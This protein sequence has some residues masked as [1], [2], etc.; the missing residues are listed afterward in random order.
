MLLRRLSFTQLAAAIGTAWLSCASAWAADVNVVGLFPGRALVEIDRGSPSMMRAGEERAGVRLISA[1]SHAAVFDIDGRRETLQLGQSLSP[2]MQAAHPHVVLRADD[3]GHFVTDGQINGGSARFV[4]DT[5]ATT[6][7]M[8]IAD[9]RRLGLDFRRAARGTAST[10]NGSIAV[11][12]VQLDSVKVGDIVLR[13]VDADILDG[14]S[15]PFVLLGMSFLSRTEMRR[16]AS[17]LTLTRM[18]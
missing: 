12:H 9:A 1:D 14:P 13:Q 18:F 3:H 16:D 8:S 6:V 4:V 2:V 11:W 17:T 10:A 7:A 5:G 15:M